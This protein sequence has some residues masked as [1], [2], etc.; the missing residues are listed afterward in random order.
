M[1]QDNHSEY[2]KLKS[3]IKTLAEKVTDVNQRIGTLN[4]QINEVKTDISTIT[5]T[6]AKEDRA[7]ESKSRLRQPTLTIEQYKDHKNTLEELKGKLP[8]LDQSLD[9]DTK[10]LAILQADLSE[11]RGSLARIR[12]LILVDIAGQSVEELTATAGE[13]FKKLVMSIIAVEGKYKGHNLRQKED[14]KTETYKIIC[15]EIIPAIFADTNELPDLDEC[16]K[17]VNSL[18]EGLLN[19]QQ[20]VAE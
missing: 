7:I 3:E 10:E 14:F 1:K 9:Y 6:L 15:G 5:D 19:E 11:K 8:T 2:F 16:N 20:R 4:S 13:S 18:I 12:D 17:Y